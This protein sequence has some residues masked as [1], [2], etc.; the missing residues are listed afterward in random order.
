MRIRIQT[1]S[2]ED[3]LNEFVEKLTVSMS[4]QE[5]RDTI[6]YVSFISSIMMYSLSYW[7]AY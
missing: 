1:F 4:A 6:I 7:S 5:T 2:S 3:E